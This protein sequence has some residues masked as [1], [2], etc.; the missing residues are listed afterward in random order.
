MADIT[1]FAKLLSSEVIAI[2]FTLTLPMLLCAQAASEHTAPP[3]AVLRPIPVWNPPFLPRTP[4]ARCSANHCL[5]LAGRGGRPDRA[6]SS[7]DPEPAAA[8]RWGGFVPVRAG[9]VRAGNT[10]HGS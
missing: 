4:A 10:E 3:P 7:A 9:H 8:G 2:F 1:I 5:L 6:H